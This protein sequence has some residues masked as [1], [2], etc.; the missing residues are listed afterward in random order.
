M[1]SSGADF[2]HLRSGFA[3]KNWKGNGMAPMRA[4]VAVVGAII[5]VVAGVAVAANVFSNQQVD[6]FAGGTHQFYVWCA[7]G[8]DYIA[9]VSGANAEDAQIKLYNENKAKGQSRC[10]PVWQARI[11]G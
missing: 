10:W 1:G 9:T 6:F 7:G 5:F 3:G 2:A 8:K 4:I 11:A